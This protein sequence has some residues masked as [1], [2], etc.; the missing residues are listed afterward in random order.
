MSILWD[1]EPYNHR[2][3]ET[4]RIYAFSLTRIPEDGQQQGETAGTLVQY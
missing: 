4:T 3:K 2:E 1:Y